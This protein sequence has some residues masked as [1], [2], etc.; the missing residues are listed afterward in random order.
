MDNSVVDELELV[1]RFENVLSSNVSDREKNN[2][3][4]GMQKGFDS[5]RIAYSGR[6]K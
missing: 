4:E 3:V 2:E 1:Q 6:F 5:N